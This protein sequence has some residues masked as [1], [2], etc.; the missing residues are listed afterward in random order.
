[1]LHFGIV[2]RMFL[3]RLNFE[4]ELLIYEFEIKHKRGDVGANLKNGT[5]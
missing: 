3:P 5:F 2:R 1:M 4:I